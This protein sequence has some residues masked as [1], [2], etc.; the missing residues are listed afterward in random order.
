[1]NLLN[2]QSITQVKVHPIVLL[3]V[4]DHFE[5]VVGQ[6]KNQRT[7]GVLL[8]KHADGICEVTNSYAVPFSESKDDKSA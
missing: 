2:S 7:I 1:M 6:K 3:S 5:R 8:G 4:V